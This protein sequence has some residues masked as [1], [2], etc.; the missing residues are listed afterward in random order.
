VDAQ[1]LDDLRDLLAL[2]EEHLG[3]TQFGDDLLGAVAL[4]GHGLT[5]SSVAKPYSQRGPISGAQITVSIT[6]DTYS[7]AIPAMQEEAA[8]LIAGLVFAAA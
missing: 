7:H 8:A 5:P 2:A 3:L 6:L 4:L 1:G